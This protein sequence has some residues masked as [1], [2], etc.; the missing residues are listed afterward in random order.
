MGFHQL[1]DNILASIPFSTLS[2][3]GLCKRSIRFWWQ[4]RTRGWDDS[5]TWSLDAVVA[6]FVLPRLIRFKEVNIAFP[7][8]FT[9]DG[10][11][12][13][14]DDM[15]YALSQCTEVKYDEDIDWDRVKRGLELFGQHFRS[16][17]W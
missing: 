3:W 14:L 4:R 11:N 8:E 9:E 1:R 7:P 6:R 15:I 2:S 5:D 16:L 10:W 13:A 12:A 17:W